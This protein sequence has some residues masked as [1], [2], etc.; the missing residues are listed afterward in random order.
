MRLLTCLFLLFCLSGISGCEKEPLR[1]GFLG[2]L[3]GKA[4]DLGVPGSRAAQM[5]V[6]E[7]NQ[8]GGLNGRPAVL[9]VE[10]DHHDADKARQAAQTLLAQDVVAVVG[11]MTSSVAMAVVEQFN[12]AETLLMGVS[13]TTNELA[14]LDDYFFRVLA[15]T[16]VYATRFAGYLWEIEGVRRIG[17]VYDRSNA[18][19]SE[20][21]AQDF[22]LAFNGFGDTSLRLAGY[23]SDLADTLEA[24]V[25]QVS[26]EPIDMLVMVSN[27]TDV[28]SLSRLA[29]QYQPDVRLAASEWAGTEHLLTLATPDM[30]GLLVQQYVSRH[31][32]E[33]LYQAFRKAYLA[34]H[35]NEPGFPGLLGYKAT[36]VVLEALRGQGEGQSLKDY[37]LARQEFQGPHGPVRF[38]PAGDSISQIFLARIRQGKYDIIQPL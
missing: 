28:V 9:L 36:R 25:R 22:S 26:L 31:F 21:W 1:I 38:T 20:G 15:P 4:A 37:I 17:L 18:S 12:Q 10:D 11:P 35:G 27:A 30:E 2:A 29:R 23:E 19:Y 3:N 6:D 8:T 32:D 5:A 24:A 7:F 33:P 14:D 34:R 13:V 16:S